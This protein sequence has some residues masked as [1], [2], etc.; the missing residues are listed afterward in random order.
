MTDERWPWW[1]WVLLAWVMGVLV[2]A[3]IWGGAR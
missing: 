3:V 2:F 1:A